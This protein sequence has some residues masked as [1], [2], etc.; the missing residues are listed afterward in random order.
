MSR[1]LERY[2]RRATEQG[3]VVHHESDTIAITGKPSRASFGLA[4]SGSLVL[5]A[6]EEPRSRA[7]LPY[8][9]YTFLSVDQIIPSIDELFAA[10]GL[11]PPSCVSIVSGP[12]SSGDI[13]MT[14]TVGVHG[15]A[16]EHVI[17][18]SP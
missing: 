16:E 6:S 13:E 12:S 8:V 7:L 17:L 1:L 14:L 3:F 15:P 9:H 18:T 4:D 2:V 5:L 10:L 11:R